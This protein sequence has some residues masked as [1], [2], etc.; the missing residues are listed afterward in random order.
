MAAARQ[1]DGT[2]ARVR[3]AVPGSGHASVE[4]GLPVLDHALALLA[5]F[6][7]VDLEVDVAADAAP[8]EIA[9]V[10]RLLGQELA[11]ALAARTARGYGAATVP[12][13]EALAHVALEASG[14]PRLVSNVDLSR[15]HVAGLATDLV[16]GFLR[17]LAEGGRLTL[18]VRLVDGEDTQHVLDAIF[19]SLG[20]AI[21]QACG[22]PRRPAAP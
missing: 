6:A 15:A 1:D 10:G 7:G 19:K 21:G 20:V 8:E 18:H 3:A 12:A 5:R 2:R 16:S 13:D 11:P 22:Q 14:R 9:T 17:E 4:T